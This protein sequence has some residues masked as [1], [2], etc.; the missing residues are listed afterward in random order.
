MSFSSGNGSSKVKAE[1][2]LP[3]VGK[4]DRDLRNR[5]ELLKS[6]HKD[7]RIGLMLALFSLQDLDEQVIEHT[8]RNLELLKSTTKHCDMK[9]IMMHPNKP[10]IG[11]RRLNFLDNPDWSK[12]YVKKSIDFCDLIQKEINPNWGELLTFHL[13]TVIAPALWKN[14]KHYWDQRFLG[15]YKHLLQLINY[16][17]F[18]K[19][20]LAIETT[21]IPEFGDVIKSDA[22]HLGDYNCYWSDLGNPWPL[23]F[24]RDEISQI[25]EVGYSIVIDWSHSYIALSTLKKINKLPDREKI[26]KRYMIYEEDLKFADS[27][28]SFSRLIN[29]NTKDGDIWHVSNAKGMHKYKNIFGAEELFYE[30]VSFDKGEISDEEINKLLGNGLNKQIK[31]VIEVNETDF[32]ESPNTRQAVGVINK[33]VSDKFFQSD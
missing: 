20:R 30:G 5:Y 21:P 31:I 26:F 7:I 9:I 28:K 11:D 3:A 33:L 17:N 2:Y 18:K 24:W 6:F 10:L 23:F 19:V 1:I 27:I 25:R 8:L 29:D 14:D 12:E 4:S 15:V 13:N 16:A 22:S 32:E